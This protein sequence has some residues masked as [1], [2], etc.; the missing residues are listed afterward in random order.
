MVRLEIKSIKDDYIKSFANIKSDDD[1]V[2]R[3]KNEYKKIALNGSE[4]PFSWKATL[5]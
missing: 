1:F 3:I 4:N 2:R 5:F